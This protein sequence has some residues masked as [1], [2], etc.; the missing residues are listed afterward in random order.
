MKGPM[1]ECVD[2]V[3]IL[4]CCKSPQD[5]R[6]AG[7]RAGRASRLHRVRLQTRFASRVC[8]KF[9]LSFTQVYRRK[10]ELG[11]RRS[12]CDRFVLAAARGKITWKIRGSINGNEQ[13]RQSVTS[14]AENCNW[15][16]CS[17]THAAICKKDGNKID[18]A[19][20]G[21]PRAM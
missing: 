9:S 21:F 4:L 11:H 17:S 5:E 12:R 3:I 2:R 16:N 8:R 7:Y 19:C 1:S 18:L 10:V 14:I 20:R 13:G 6:I 15:S